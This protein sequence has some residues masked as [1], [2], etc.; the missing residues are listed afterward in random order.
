M[1][2][3]GDRLRE[4]EGQQ[5]A[6]GQRSQEARGHYVMS[7]RKSVAKSERVTFPDGS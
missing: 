1:P 6:G 3:G 4:D 5:D 7:L 2:F